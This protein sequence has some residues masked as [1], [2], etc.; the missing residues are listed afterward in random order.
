MTRIAFDPVEGLLR[1]QGDLERFLGK[2]PYNF[3]LSGGNV[4][5]PVNIFTDGDGYVIQAEIPGVD[6]NNITVKVE[7]GQLTLAGERTAPNVERASYLR[8]ER[9]FGRFSRTIQLPQDADLEHVTAEFRNGVLSV[10]IPKLAAAK[11][12]QVEVRAA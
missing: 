4:Y 8:R 1:L 11:P 7:S 10:R 9:R 5:P 12:H 3:G 6:P 2:P